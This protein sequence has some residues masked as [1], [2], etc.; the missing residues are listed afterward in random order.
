MQHTSAQT[1]SVGQI[2]DICWICGG[3]QDKMNQHK[4]VPMPCHGLMANNA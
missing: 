3:M 2:L 4:V 1:P